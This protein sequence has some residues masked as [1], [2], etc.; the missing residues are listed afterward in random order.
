LGRWTGPGDHAWIDVPI[1]LP[2]GTRVEWS[3]AA[4]R[5]RDAYGKI[6][7]DVN[8]VPLDLDRSA[9]DGGFVLGGTVPDDYRSDRRFT[10]VSIR[11]PEPVPMRGTPDPRKISLGVT[12]L[13]LL[14][15]APGPDLRTR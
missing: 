7:V 12:E 11:T 2:P 8:G 10:R 6:S 14:V 1:Q 5:E 15:P 3:V 4:V 9:H 13:R